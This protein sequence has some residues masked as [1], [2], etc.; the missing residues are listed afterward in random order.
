MSNAQDELLIEVGQPTQRQI[1][2]DL[3]G[4][5]L[6]DINYALDGGLNADLIQNGDFEYNPRDHK[7]WGP[8]TAWKTSGSVSIR[9]AD[10]L[11]PQTAV[12]ARVDATHGTAEL[13]NYGFSP[14]YFPA[15]SLRLRFAARLADTA[16]GQFEVELGD[17]DDVLASATVRL[18]GQ[19]EGW[20]FYEATLH[21]D[22]DVQEGYLRLRLV[23]GTV[24]LDAVSLR[25]ID[26]QTHTPMTFRPDLVQALAELEPS[27]VRF[28]GGCVAHGYGLDNIYHW[29]GSVGPRHERKRLHNPWGYH[30]SMSIGYFEYFELCEKLGA[31]PMPIVAAG[32]CCQNLPGRARAIPSGQ[33]PQYI[34]DVLDLIEFANG[35]VDT[36][37]GAYRAEL[38]HP[39]PFN[40][41]YLGVGNEDEI[42]DDFRDRFAQIHDAVR[43]RYPHIKVV[44]TCGPAPFGPDFEQGWE[45]ARER[46]VDVIDEHGYR[47]PH[48]MHQNLDR[49]DSYDR[50]GPTV[51]FGEYA[52]RSSRLRS[53][54][55]EAAFMIGM[56]RNGDVVHLASYAPLL[57]RLGSTQWEPNLLYFTESE[58]RPSV[59]Y[60]VQRMF[61]A[62]RGELVNEVTVSGVDEQ[63]RTMPTDST[64]RL[65]SPGSTVEWTEIS[66][67]AGTEKS[68]VATT[69]DGAAED[70][71]R[72]DGA[73]LDF[74]AHLTRSN[75]TEG[76]AI[77]FGGTGLQTRYT[78]QVGSWEN[79]ST[80][81][82]RHDDGLGDEISG[83]FAYPGVVTHRP[84]H[85][86]LRVH[87]QADGVHIQL[88]LD[89][90]LRHDVLD[91]NTPDLLTVVGATAN[92][93]GSRI[94]RIVNATDRARSTT[95][96]VGGDREVQ[97]T[98]ET[99]TGP[100]PEGGTGESW[101]QP[102][103]THL[104][105]T[106]CLQTVVPAWSFTTLNIS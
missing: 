106:G 33:M 6:E 94:V 66:A 21:V 76:A 103:V 50:Q 79:K 54:L 16:A 82:V 15:G 1:S 39:E 78:V 68:Q 31:S 27:F 51:Y 60:Q 55:A 91:P 56:E 32:V 12:H 44:G 18:T 9:T 2:P 35:S 26:P 61:S 30:Q 64:V 83:P 53:A 8:L 20:D 43:D 59:N 80:V 84:I 98:A 75:G 19:A 23:K 73:D 58:V 5:F 88:W 95:I 47:T 101:P 48:W 49:Y 7:G 38:G 42:T 99:L 34:A 22:R 13:T 92:P 93:D 10:P 37:W 87:T 3:W 81:V 69:D 86:R 40:L 74:Q 70:V 62:N 29:K 102:P 46:G 90:E 72:F 85:V 14:M 63:L 57:A 25:P 4:I 45:Y 36:V 11:T 17:G 104:Q 65:S 52:A 24:D 67:G 96:T 28:P 71:A 100:D 41:R 89:G 97:A 77:S 105:G